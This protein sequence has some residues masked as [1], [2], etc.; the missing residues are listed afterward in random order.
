LRSVYFDT[1]DRK[2]ER[3]GLALRLRK[4][5]S[6]WVQTLKTDPDPAVG[7]F[8]RTEIEADAAGDSPELDKIS[9]PVLRAKV[10]KAAASGGLVPMVE[11]DIR[12]TSKK[13]KA[14]DGSL[15]QLDL[16]VGEIRTP[17]ASEPVRELEL[18]LI[19]GHEGALHDLALGF[20]GDGIKLSLSLESKAHRGQRLLDGDRVAGPVKADRPDIPEGATVESA[21]SLIVLSCLS[22]I[23]ANEAASRDGSDP[24]GVHQMRVGVRRLRSALSVFGKVLP[25]DQTAPLKA[26][27][28]WLFSALGQARDIDVF[29]AETLTAIEAQA[30]DDTLA[31]DRLRA[32]G[33]GVRAEAYRGLREVLDDPRYTKLMLTLSRW[34]VSRSWRA[35]QVSEDSV[36]LFQPI[37]SFA[38]ER[39]KKRHN[40]VVRHGKHLIS[41]PIAERHEVRLEVKKLRYVV[42]FYSSLYGRK[43]VKPYVKALARIQ[44]TL[45]RLNDGATAAG[46]LDRLTRHRGK[47]ASAADHRTAGFVMGWIENQARHELETLEADWAAFIGTRPFW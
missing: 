39:L 34:L 24:E 37:K 41:L 9:N 35:Q 13:L 5:G 8:Q 15:I 14:P 20:L 7:L 3:D 18:E 25:E 45:G 40:R 46:V 42:D 32:A 29:L 43:R 47:T 4:V 16:D 27:L 38:G 2:L 19:G 31:L 6:R 21:F 1:A 28:K 33:E 11:T 10:D 30:G 22:Q 26:E 36:R 23:L 44:G 17:N 12:R